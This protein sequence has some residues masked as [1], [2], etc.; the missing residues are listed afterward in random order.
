[1]NFQIAIG[2]RVTMLAVIAIWANAAG[3]QQTPQSTG[4]AM[5]NPARANVDTHPVKKKTRL[6]DRLA[7]SPA[8]AAKNEQGNQAVV[9]YATGI[10]TQKA[11]SASK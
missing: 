6:H 2:A 11:R 7:D 4:E 8:K 10:P 1:M 5:T 9:E 3:A